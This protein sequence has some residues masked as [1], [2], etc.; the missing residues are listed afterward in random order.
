MTALIHSIMQAVSDP[1]VWINGILIGSVYAAM[2]VGFT[3]IWG[4]AGVINLAQGDMMMLGAFTTWST[5]NAL[6]PVLGKS[7]FLLFIVGLVAALVLVGALGYILQRVLINRVMS[8]VGTFL[9]LLLTFGIG[10]T[11]RQAA[12]IYWGSN[13]RSMDPTIPGPNSY[14][15]FGAVIPSVRLTIF[16]IAIILAVAFYLFLQRTRTGRAI[17]ATSQNE[18]AADIV[19]IDID[20]IYSTTYA[21]TAGTA[22]ITGGLIGLAFSFQPLMGN[23]YTTRSFVVVVIGGL[24]SVPGA[25]VGGI[26]LGLVQQFGANIWSPSLTDA[27]AF[28]VLV[29]FLLVKPHGLFGEEEEGE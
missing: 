27:V 1:S 21:I 29:V 7:S 26:L 9:T 8:A 4:V 11:I 15:L 25:F 10:L 20:N 12:L 6:A 5:M 22:A 24:G 13:P 16:V 3:L 2:A 17:R 18:R 28:T 14:H 19:G 23:A